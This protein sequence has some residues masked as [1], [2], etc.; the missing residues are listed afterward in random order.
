M[1]MKGIL[2]QKTQQE[3]ILEQFPEAVR[4]GYLSNTTT[5]TFPSLARLS[6]NVII[7]D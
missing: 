4:I 7:K 1:L 5:F 2:F 3:R 6:N